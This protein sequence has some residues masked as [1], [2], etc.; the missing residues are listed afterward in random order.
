MDLD[1]SIVSDDDFQCYNTAEGKRVHTNIGDKLIFLSKETTLTPETGIKFEK[2]PAEPKQTSRRS[3]RLPFAKQ[4]EKLNGVQNYTE[5][6][7]KK[8][9]NF[10]VLQESRNCQPGT[11][12]DEEPNNRI[13]RRFLNI[14]C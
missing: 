8:V 7:K 9:N 10:C 3:Q 4:T 5:N 2:N 1:L 14:R 12:S 6:N 13:I 11:N